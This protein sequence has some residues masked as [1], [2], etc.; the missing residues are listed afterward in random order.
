MNK[1]EMGGGLSDNRHAMGIATPHGTQIA[2]PFH[3]MNKSEA[4][5]GRQSSVNEQDATQ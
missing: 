2:E 3:Y 1:S 4:E 5:F